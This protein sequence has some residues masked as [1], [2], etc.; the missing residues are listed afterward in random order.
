MYHAL[1]SAGRAAAA[2][3]AVAHRDVIPAIRARSSHF[4]APERPAPR[5]AR[6]RSVGG[7]HYCDRR[8]RQEPPRQLYCFELEPEV[9]DWRDSL[10]DSDFKRVDEVAGMLAEKGS[11]LG[12]PWSDHLEGPVWELRVRLHQVAARGTYRCRP[13]GTIVLLTVFREDPPA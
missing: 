9:R 10:S 13:D 6:R 4:Q 7:C 8:E 2:G 3:A 11:G 1:R 5:A 12:R